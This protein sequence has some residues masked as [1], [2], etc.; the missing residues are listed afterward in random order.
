MCESLLVIEYFFLK[1]LECSNLVGFMGCLVF[2]ILKS[3]IKSKDFK[4]EISNY[5]NSGKNIKELM[6]F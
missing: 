2:Q 1:F 5:E 4:N 3:R 6:S